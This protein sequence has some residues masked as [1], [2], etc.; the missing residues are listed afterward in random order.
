MTVAPVRSVTN[1]SSHRNVARVATPAA[2]AASLLM[3]TSLGSISTPTPRAPKSRA[4]AITTRPSPLPRS[5]TRSS[6][7][8][9]AILS[10]SR[11]TASGVAT[12]STSG[13]GKRARTAAQPATTR[14]PP[15]TPSAWRLCIGHRGDRAGAAAGPREGVRGERRRGRHRATVGDLARVGQ[16]LL[17][18]LHRVD[19]AQ[20][21]RPAVRVEEDHVGLAARPQAAGEGQA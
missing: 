6:A 13:P 10:I 9:A 8:T 3:L 15:S 20:P 18:R 21:E 12:K 11:L 5:T 16:Y 7:V 14:T 4:A 17:E 19:A 2:R 1:R